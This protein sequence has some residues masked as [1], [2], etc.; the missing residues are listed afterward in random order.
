MEPTGRLMRSRAVLLLAM[1]LLALLRSTAADSEPLAGKVV[2]VTDGD[3]ITV[4]VDRRPVGVAAGRS[5]WIDAA[6]GRRLEHGR[7]VRRGAILPGATGKRVG[8]PW[9][10]SPT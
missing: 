5:D 6:A 7:V 1:G 8:R 4:L 2:T 10:C 9:G 3:T